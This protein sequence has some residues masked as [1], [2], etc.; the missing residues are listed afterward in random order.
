M[1]LM[2][3]TDLLVPSTLISCQC[4]SWWF[5]YFE[6]CRNAWRRLSL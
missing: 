4:K 3:F 5:P 2:T 1:L 6:M